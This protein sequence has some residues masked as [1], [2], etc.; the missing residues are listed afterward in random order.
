[1]VLELR[2]VVWA[3]ILN[4]GDLNI[5]KVVNAQVQMRSP[6]ERVGGVGHLSSFF[7]SEQ[8]FLPW[9]L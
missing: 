8:E 6:R 3:G 9:Y 1:M 7:L 5:S 4:W 2:R